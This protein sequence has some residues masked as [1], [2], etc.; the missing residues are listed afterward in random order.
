MVFHVSYIYNYDVP[1]NLIST[2]IIIEKITKEKIT[3]Q[4]EI[5]TIEPKLI[6]IGYI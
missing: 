5:E 1:L 6:N 2:K 4:T 3:N